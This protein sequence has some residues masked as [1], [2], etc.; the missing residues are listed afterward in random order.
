[1]SSKWLT[2]ETYVWDYLDVVKAKVYLDIK[3]M[4]SVSI[5]EDMD[6]Y[7]DDGVRMVL[8]EFV[9]PMIDIHHNGKD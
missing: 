4:Y 7:I 1:M 8:T 3:N 5:I 6:I 9:F 2:N